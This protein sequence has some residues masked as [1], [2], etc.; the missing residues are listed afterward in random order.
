MASIK[1]VIGTC[2]GGAPEAIVDGITGYIV[3]PLYT[4]EIAKKTLDLL[5]NPK[6]AEGFG[7]NGYERVKDDFN[8]RKK[9]KEYTAI[10]ETLLEE[11]E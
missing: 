1:P 6:K 7:K 5:N 11:K 3:N 2:Y 8:L 9:I 10:Y 4:D